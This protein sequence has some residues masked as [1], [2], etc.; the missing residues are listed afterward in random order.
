MTV[1]IYLRSIVRNGEKHLAMFDSKRE[2]DIDNLTTIANPG[3]NVLWKLDRCSGIQSITKIY[4]K[5]GK[6]KIFKNDPKKLLFGRGFEMLIPDFPVRA[7]EE[8]VEAYTIEFV[9]CNKTKMKIDPYIK[10]PAEK[11]PK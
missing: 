9:T 6:G 10:L 8:V 3:D 11:I 2:G 1:K 5:E 7:G 4:P